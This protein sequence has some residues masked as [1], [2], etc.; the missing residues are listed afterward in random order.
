MMTVPSPQ[1][2]EEKHFVV[3]SHLYVTHLDDAQV[4][5]VWESLVF[6]GF[7]GEVMAMTLSV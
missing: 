3:P 5:H 4:F 6:A 7:E 1:L 2:Q